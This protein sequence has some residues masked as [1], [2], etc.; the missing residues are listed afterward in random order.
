L[1][2]FAVSTTGEGVAVG[3]LEVLVATGAGSALGLGEGKRVGDGVGVSESIS[4]CWLQPAKKRRMASRRP[5]Q[6]VIFIRPIIS[7]KH[8]LHQSLS[9]SLP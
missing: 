7:A 8:R 1:D 5:V 9:T 3:G 6:V 2:S 4:G